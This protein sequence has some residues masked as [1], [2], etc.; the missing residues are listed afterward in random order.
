MNELPVK[1]SAIW[2]GFFG[3]KWQALGLSPAAL[4][5]VGLSVTASRLQNPQQLS[6]HR[7]LAM[8]RDDALAY[9]PTSRAITTGG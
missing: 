4:P 6:F 3:T 9:R 2:R 1:L 8:P 7:P 5:S